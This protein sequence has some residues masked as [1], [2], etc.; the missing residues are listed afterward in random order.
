MENNVSG[1]KCV[2]FDGLPGSAGKIVRGLDGDFH[3]VRAGEVEFKTIGF[4]SRVRGNG[5]PNFCFE[6][7]PRVAPTGCGVEPQNF[8]GEVLRKNGEA[9][10]W[11]ASEEG[12]LFQFCRT[13]EGRS[14]D[15]CQ[16]ASALEGF[17]VGASVKSILANRCDIVGE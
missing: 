4:H 12:E 10:G 5:L 15:G 13:G 1:L 8:D 11:C 9:K 3:A 16:K 2:I 17:E 14:A 6:P 7:V